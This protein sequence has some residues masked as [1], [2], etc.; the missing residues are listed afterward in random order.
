MTQDVRIHLRAGNGS[1]VL[2]LE[3]DLHERSV[4]PGS[5]GR[6]LRNRCCLAGGPCLLKRSRVGVGLCDHAGLQA[7]VLKRSV[8]QPEAKLEA[9]LNVVLNNYQLSPEKRLRNE[10]AH[11][12]E[13]AVV[14]QETLAIGDTEDVVGRSTSDQLSTIVC[15]ALRDRVGKTTGGVVVSIQDIHNGVARLLARDT[16]PNQR[17][18]IGMLNPCID[19]SRSDGVHHYDGI[20]VVVCDSRDEVVSIAPKR[21]VLTT[22]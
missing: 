18:D 14:N 12:I 20:L 2:N 9:G 8:T 3:S 21:Q 15:S 19:N 22:E 1:G 4:E 17:C 6:A 13:V 7:E 16:C 11:S 10:M 5:S